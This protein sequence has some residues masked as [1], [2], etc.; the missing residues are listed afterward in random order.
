MLWLGGHHRDVRRQAVRAQHLR[1]VGAAGEHD[2]VIVVIAHRETK[3]SRVA[4]QGQALGLLRR[5]QQ[6]DDFH[7]CRLVFLLLDFLRDR[8]HLD[9]LQD[10]LGE[11]P[12]RTFTA[13][14]RDQHVDPGMRQ[15]EARD[16][17]DFVNRNRHRA[18]PK[19]DQQ[20]HHP[21]GLVTGEQL[22]LDDRLVGH[23]RV[24]NVAADDLLGVRV[25]TLGHTVGGPAC[26]LDLTQLDPAAER[27]IH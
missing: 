18:H 25:G 17:A 16:I 14:D 5:D 4:G 10:Y 26:H 2:L 7:H 24:L 11:L 22:G 8:E 13:V 23:Q 21:G 20:R 3:R 9:V 12:F 15:N 19:R 1:Y 27:K 6:G